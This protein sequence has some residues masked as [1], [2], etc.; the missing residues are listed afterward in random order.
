[1]AAA[2]SAGAE[3]A[4]AFHETRHTTMLWTKQGAMG[5]IGEE[6]TRGIGLRMLVE[7]RVEFLRGSAL[8][9]ADLETEIGAM[10]SVW[11]D[12]RGPNQAAGGNR[13]AEAVGGRSIAVDAGFEFPAIDASRIPDPKSLQLL[14]PAL[15]AAGLQD[16]IQILEEAQTTALGA[17]PALASRGFIIE[18]HVR[19]VDIASSHGTWMGYDSGRVTLG[20]RVAFR[21][22]PGRV[23]R[24]SF[25]TRSLAAL[26]D[27][28]T[29]DL[30]ARLGSRAVTLRRAAPVQPPR[31]LAEFT[32]VLPPDHAARIL[33]GL[34]GAMSAARVLDDASCLAGRLGETIG[35]ELLNVVDDGTLPGGLGSAPFDGEGIPCAYHHPIVN[36]R[37][38]S[39]LFDSASARR[40]NVAP[41]GNA[42]RTSFRHLPAIRPRNWILGPGHRTPEELIGLVDHGLLLLDADPIGARWVDLASGR[43]ALLAS[44]QLI[45][46]GA[47]GRAAVLPI[48]SSLLE[49]LS[50]LSAL[51]HDLAWSGSIAC[52]TIAVTGFRF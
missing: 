16:L 46:H 1:M 29:R 14:D 5:R 15:A 32:V 50:G 44:G 23:T 33:R 2:R 7:G 20:G 18:R 25:A 9:D 17:S 31:R 10:L 4:E 30:A 35:S 38:Q 41:T 24:G 13:G 21:E 47:L 52:P 45:E 19:H 48:E 22:A 12:A 36:G 6:Q 26:T 43:I 39:Y 49:L 8:S 3:A 11:R 42:E 40:M 27:S 34:A 28:G 37:L 51:A